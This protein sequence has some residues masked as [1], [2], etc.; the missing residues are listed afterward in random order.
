MYISPTYLIFALPA[1][2]LG[3]Y[4]QARVQ[5][6]YR[7]YLRVPNARGVTG[8]AAARE[9]LSVAGLSNVSIEGTSGALTDHYDPRTRTLRLS[10]GV[11][12][13]P[14]VASVAIVAHEVGHA[15]QHATGYTPMKVR[16][17]LVPVVNIGSWLGPILFILGLMMASTE[18]AT[19]GLVGFSLAA[20]FALVT[21]PVELN[22]SSRAL[23]MLQSSGII[24]GDEV[25]GA[26]SVLTAAALTYI[27]AL[28]Q[29]ISTIL[30]YATLLTGLRRD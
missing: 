6:A 18:L 4:A 13:T 20:V 28:A 30:Y 19:V 24:M 22:A 23:A 26:R 8:L 3:L 9:L 11:A 17:S 14:S 16:S 27:A 29:A 12:D 7:K 1:L 25:A 15:V 21:V 10:R 5:S 2:I